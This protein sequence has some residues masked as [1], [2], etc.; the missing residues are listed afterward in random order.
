VKRGGGAS[1]TLAATGSA[2]RATGQ[3]YAGEA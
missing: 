3:S 2:C 1:S